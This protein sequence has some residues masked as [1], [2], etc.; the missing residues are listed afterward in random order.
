MYLGGGGGEKQVSSLRQQDLSVLRVC[1]VR[2]HDGV[3]LEPW[4]RHLFVR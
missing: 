3:S 1:D 4:P 2:V